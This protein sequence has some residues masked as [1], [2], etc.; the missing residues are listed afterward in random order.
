M[1]SSETAYANL[2]QQANQ[3]GPFRE[4]LL[5]IL[6][7]VGIGDTRAN[8]G[9]ILD[10]EPSLVVQAWLEKNEKVLWLL[11]KV[12]KEVESANDPSSLAKAA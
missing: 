7:F 12:G 4:A 2:A 5:G 8:I 9:A 11:W 6:W 3:I 10:R 1:T